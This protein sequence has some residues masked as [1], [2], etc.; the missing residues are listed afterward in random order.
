ML[1]KL[2]FAGNEYDKD[3]EENNNAE[4]H[5]DVSG[6]NKDTRANITVYTFCTSTCISLMPRYVI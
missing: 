4:N 5:E 3:D 1:A 2:C 6:N